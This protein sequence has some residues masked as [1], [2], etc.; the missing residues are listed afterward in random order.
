[1]KD[2][3]FIQ[4]Y[5]RIKDTNPRFKGQTLYDLSNGFSDTYDLCKSKG[6]FIWVNHSKQMKGYGN[7]EHINDVSLPIDKGTVYISVY[8]LTQLYQAYKWAIMYPN[9][10]FI[11][12]GPSANSKNYLVKPN[13]FPSNMT[14]IEK[15]VED[16]FNVPNFSYPWKLELPDEPHDMWLTYTYTLR[17]SCYWGKCNFCNFS[18][19][20]R[21]RPKINFEFLDVDY[22]GFQRIALYT[23]SV[24]SMQLKSLFY[25]LEYDRNIRYDIYL[26]GNK[27]ERDTLKEIFKKRTTKFPQ[28][29]F[30]IGVEFPSD[31]MLSYMN[32][33]ATVNGILKTINM[34]SNYGHED[35]QIGLSFILGWNNIEQSDMDSLNSFL[36]KLPYDKIKI[37]FSVN[38]LKAK[39]YTKVFDEYEVKKELYVGPFLSGFEPLINK[40]QMAY[41][42]QAINMFYNYNVTV[43]DWN[44]IR[45]LI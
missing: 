22:N 1:M 26:R 7:D 16:Y 23:P 20:T 6:D 2:T 40:E 35:I 37:S 19:G 21:V 15:T 17:S 14:I 33:N 38:L 18:Y 3:L 28:T 12:G 43:F 27:P 29:K 36:D 25:K 13:I 5:T 8:Y 31:R 30:F 44:N 39:P 42:K 11:I 24:T 45:N 4:F 41:S 10:K 9:I 32:K 34:L